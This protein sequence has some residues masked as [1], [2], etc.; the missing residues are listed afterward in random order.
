MNFLNQ[1]FQKQRCAHY[2]YKG[3]QLLSSLMLFVGFITEDATISKA[4]HIASTNNV[5]FVEIIRL[6]ALRPEQKKVLSY[7]FVDRSA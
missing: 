5:G 3:A 7:G 6:N 4:N 2:Q 1:T